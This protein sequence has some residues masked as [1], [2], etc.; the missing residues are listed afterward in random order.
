MSARTSFPSGL[1]WAAALGEYVADKIVQG[2]EEL[3]EVLS[4]R[5]PFTIG[6]RVQRVLG[7]PVSFALSHAAAKLR[8]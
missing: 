6:P 3:D 2:R 5:R 8:R 1:P 7:K 4:P